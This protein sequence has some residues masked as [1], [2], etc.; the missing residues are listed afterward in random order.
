M[1]SKLF[2]KCKTR[3]KRTSRTKS[4]KTTVEAESDSEREEAL[5]KPRVV[6]SDQGC[7]RKS[8]PNLRSEVEAQVSGMTRKTSNS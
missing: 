5:R 3:K 2:S 4:K 8:S 6:S 7:T 1:L